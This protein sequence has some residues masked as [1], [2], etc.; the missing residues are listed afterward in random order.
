MLRKTILPTFQAVPASG[1]AGTAT[2]ELPLGRRYHVIWLQL[3]CNGAAAANV[4]NGNAGNLAAT[5]ANAITDIRVKLNGHTQRI[6]TGR[7]LNEINESLG[8][9]YA[10]QATGTAGTAGYK[11]KIPIFFAER[12][13]SNTVEQ[14]LPAWNVDGGQESFTIEVDVNATHGAAQN[15]NIALS[16]FYEWEPLTGKLGPIAKWFRQTFSAT[17]TQN[18]FSLKEREGFLQAIHLF[19]TSDGKF[20]NKVKLTA[21]GAD[22]QDLLDVFENSSVLKAAQMN[23]DFSAVPRFDLVLDYDDPLNSALRLDGLSDLTMQAQY[24]ATAAGSLPCIFVRAGRPE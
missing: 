14:D 17:G 5:I 1:T 9:A 4:S 19:N 21:N 11:L 10:A 16:G 7:Q 24:S 20:V 2:V 12:W 3:T 6:S 23:P 8:T 18:D 22:V 15:V 13:R